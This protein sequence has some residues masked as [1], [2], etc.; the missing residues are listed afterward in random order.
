MRTPKAAIMKNPWLAVTGGG[1]ESGGCSCPSG[2]ANV[3]EDADS[4]RS[5]VSSVGVAF[6]EDILVMGG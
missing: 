4:E 5:R 1:A 3:D 6:G 2:S